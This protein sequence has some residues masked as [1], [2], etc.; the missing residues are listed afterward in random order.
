MIDLLQ[1]APETIPAERLW[2]NPGSV[3]KKRDWSE[4]RGAL[5]DLT[6]AAA[7]LRGQQTAKRQTN[8]S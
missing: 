2:V 5:M 7:A 6:Q 3:L 8:I 4:E 1:R